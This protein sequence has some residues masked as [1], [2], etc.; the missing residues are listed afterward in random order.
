MARWAQRWLV[1]ASLGLLAAQALIGCN[2]NDGT[3]KVRIVASDAGF[4]PAEV[5]VP[6]GRPA[7]LEVT[8]VSE[9]SCVDSVRMP[10][11]AEAIDLPL[12]ETIAIVIPD[13]SKA[14]TFVYSCWMNMLHGKVIIDPATP[15]P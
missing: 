13:T 6:Q 3:I 2:E 1:G 14:G 12:N 8:R 5:H 15:A 9:S 7:V 11:S 4:E 10:W